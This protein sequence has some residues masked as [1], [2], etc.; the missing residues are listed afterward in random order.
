VF[1]VVSEHAS[2]GSETVTAR[3]GVT[4]A[5]ARK[6]SLRF[7]ALAS[8]FVDKR[9]SRNASLKYFATAKFNFKAF[10]RAF[11]REPLKSACEQ[12]EKHNL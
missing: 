9:S 4:C 1:F 5:S 6:R 10:L 3:S 12:T 7:N 11:V 8:L 2:C